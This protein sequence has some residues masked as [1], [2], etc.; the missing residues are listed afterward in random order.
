[1]DSLNHGTVSVIPRLINML[2]VFTDIIS[3]TIKD[4]TMQ[5]ELIPAPSK[6]SI[7]SSVASLV[8][9]SQLPDDV[10]DLKTLAG[11]SFLRSLGFYPTKDPDIFCWRT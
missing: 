10:A 2:R 3:R 5:L 1:M 9:A 11:H 6:T 4:M 8:R 7:F